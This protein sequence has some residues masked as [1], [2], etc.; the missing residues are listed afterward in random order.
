MEGWLG[1]NE[2]RGWVG[3][4]GREVGRGGGAGTVH[5]GSAFPNLHGPVR[6][7]D[8]NG[9]VRYCRKVLLRRSY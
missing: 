7:R 5:F 9:S 1:W 3:G 6:V 4:G 8:G 2:V